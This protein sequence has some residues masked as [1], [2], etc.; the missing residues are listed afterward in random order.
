M[1]YLPQLISPSQRS[2]SG[3]LGIWVSSC[4]QKCYM[5]SSEHE[6]PHILNT[7]S[8]IHSMTLLA[9]I[10][11]DCPVMDTGSSL[12]N[13]LPVHYFLR[14]FSLKI[15][16]LN[17]MVSNQW[18]AAMGT[19]RLQCRFGGHVGSWGRSIKDRQQWVERS[20]GLQKSQEEMIYAAS[21]REKRCLYLIAF[22]F[23][24]SP[25]S[26][27]AFELCETSLHPFTSHHFY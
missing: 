5:P 27:L 11:A 8:S 25:T 9:V 24:L 18:V 2:N 20:R 3:N 13:S 17:N 14:F 4:T 26:C 22:W 12:P 16:K 10:R 15:F 1:A 19:E 6:L 23:P 7:R 21:V